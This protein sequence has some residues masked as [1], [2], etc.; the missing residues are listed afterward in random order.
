MLTF[1]NRQTAC[2]QSG[3][4]GGTGGAEELEEARAAGRFS[5]SLLLVMFPFCL[6]PYL[7]HC[8]LQMEMGKERRKRNSDGEV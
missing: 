2:L 3:E 7:L 6:H 1:C 4:E 8:L 5:G